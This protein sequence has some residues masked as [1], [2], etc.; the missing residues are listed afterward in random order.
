MRRAAELDADA[1][2][3]D[4][5][6]TQAWRAGNCR[7]W[8][9]GRGPSHGPFRC[10]N[11]FVGRRPIGRKTGFSEVESEVPEKSAYRK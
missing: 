2:L 10:T 9:P 6:Y 4:A 11:A 5:E 8:G 3:L 1:F 7:V